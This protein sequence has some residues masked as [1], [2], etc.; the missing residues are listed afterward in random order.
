[1]GKL[2]RAHVWWSLYVETSN[3]R[4][5]MEAHLPPINEALEHIEFDWEIT[6]NAEGTGLYRL[7][8]YQNLSG[9]TTERIIVPVLRRAY[10]LSA[11][12]TIQGLEDL[13]NGLRHVIGSCINPKSSNR[14]P[15]LK[16]LMFEIEP[17]IVGPREADG[18]WPI[19]NVPST[20]KPAK[21]G[22]LRRPR[23]P[24]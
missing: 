9:T 22:Q 2:L 7:V 4:K 19:T 1:M 14:P 12:W 18:G 11:S 13:R 3:K 10:G 5:L 24:D 23:A 6:A 8:T 16:S 21:P 17:G 15:A 20:R